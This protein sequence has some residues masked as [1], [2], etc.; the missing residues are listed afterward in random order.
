MVFKSIWEKTTQE[1]YLSRDEILSMA[2]H[3]KP[4][5]DVQEI[6]ILK[7][8]CRNLN[9][10]IRFKELSFP[11]IIRV[12]IHDT[13]AAYREQELANLLTS[14]VP[15]PHIY[16]IRQDARYRFALMEYISGIPLGEFLLKAKEREI[17]TVM[18][19]IA[20]LLT[21][22]QEVHFPKEGR[23]DEHL[24]PQPF[25]E[26]SFVPFI[27]KCLNHPS[28]TATL[29]LKDREK[30]KL[31]FYAHQSYLPSGE[32]K[33]VHGD[34]DPANILVDYQQ[35]QWHVSGILDWEFAHSGSPLLDI[36]NMLRYAHYMPLVFKDA[37]IKGLQTN[38]MILPVTWEKSVILLN[39]LS[40]LDC[41]ARSSPARQPNRCQD[42]CQL[43]QYFISGLEY[44]D[45]GGDR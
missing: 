37:F 5:N 26:S 29:S 8:G 30:I 33:L 31:C 19:E 9:I 36:A 15:I 13:K 45:I 40:L 14:K 20:C 39:I 44:A 18:E 6:E 17:G 3:L 2:R 24:Q 1:I 10:K 7:G 35:G 32:T 25:E 27:E 21:L 28:V 43:L 42:I 4:E 22:I 23:L 11:F 34:F 16:T 12:Y 41:L 38:G